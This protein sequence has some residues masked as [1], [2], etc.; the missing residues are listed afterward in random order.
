M[1]D[2]GY[3]IRDM[4]VLDIARGVWGEVSSLICAGV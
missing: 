4:W 1:V 3:S 2:Q